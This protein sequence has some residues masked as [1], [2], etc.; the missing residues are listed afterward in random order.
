MQVI[1]NRQTEARDS[2]INNVQKFGSSSTLVG[3]G[4]DE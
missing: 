4:N 2:K 1:I 3:N